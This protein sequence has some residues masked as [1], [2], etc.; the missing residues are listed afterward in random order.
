MLKQF[1]FRRK[2]L[3][4]CIAKRREPVKTGFSPLFSAKNRAKMGCFT[5]H[6]EKSICLRK[7]STGFS[8]FFSGQVGAQI[9]DIESRK[10]KRYL[11][12]NLHFFCNYS[13]CSR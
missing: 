2:M 13:G 8:G 6:L 7:I 4:I 5:K 11:F 9:D 1:G 3:Y 12:S 10:V